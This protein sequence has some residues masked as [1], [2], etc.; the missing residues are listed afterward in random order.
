MVKV[1]WCGK[2]A[3]GGVGQ[4]AGAEGPGKHGGD[5]K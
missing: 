1:S 2:N 5:P 3:E 4:A